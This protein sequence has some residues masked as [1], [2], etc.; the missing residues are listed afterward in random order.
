MLEEIMKHKCKDCGKTFKTYLVFE[1]HECVK[2][3]E[4][5]S[6][7]DLEALLAKRRKDNETH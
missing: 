2:R 1:H 5:L 4:A 3:L 6:L 7:A